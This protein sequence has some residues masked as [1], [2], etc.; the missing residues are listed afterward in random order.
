MNTPLQS[1]E[2]RVMPATMLSDEPIDEQDCSSLRREASTNGVCFVQI[3][4][5]LHDGT[6]LARVA[7]HPELLPE[8]GF[9]IVLT[10]AQVAGNEHIS[11]ECITFAEAALVG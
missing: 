9:T 4:R 11:K 8:Q 3:I 6:H 2:Y 5:L 7:A 1:A 10:D